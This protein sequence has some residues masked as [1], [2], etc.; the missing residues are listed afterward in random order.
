MEFWCGV[1]VTLLIESVALI[2]G[3]EWL[4]KK[5][6]EVDANELENRGN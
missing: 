3:R 2:L 6:R 5:I 1:A 4:R